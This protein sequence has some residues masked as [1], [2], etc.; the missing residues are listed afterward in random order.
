MARDPGVGLPVSV[1]AS[2]VAPEPSAERR[3][4]FLDEDESVPAPTVRELCR[5]GW[6]AEIVTSLAAAHTALADGPVA[7]VILRPCGIAGRGFALANVIRRWAPTVPVGVELGGSRTDQGAAPR[8]MGLS[9]TPISAEIIE[10]VRL[11]STPRAMGRRRE[12]PATRPMFGL[13][14]PVAASAR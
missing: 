8:M 4:L 13:I 6:D 3:I 5:V 9:R 12:P 10:A 2:H 11:C 1:I 14:A 7:A